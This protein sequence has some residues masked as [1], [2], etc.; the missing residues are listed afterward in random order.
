MKKILL[1]LILISFVI[2]SGCGK[3]DDKV[4]DKSGD[5]KTEDVKKDDASNQNPDKKDDKNST[6]NSLQMTDGLPKN[7]PSDIPQP[8]TYKSV[9]TLPGTDG[10]FVIF[11]TSDKVK[12]IVDFYQEEM[13]KNGFEAIEGG[14]NLVSENVAQMGWKKKDREINVAVTNVDNS[15]TQIVITYK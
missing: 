6:T 12:N 2:F 4:T 5:K 14:D 13:K 1:L 10:T 9:R 11:E 8:K 3:K 7:F 15:N